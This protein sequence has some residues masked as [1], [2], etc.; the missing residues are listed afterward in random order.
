VKQKRGR[1]GKV[2]PD[3]VRAVRRWFV[4]WN[5]IKRPREIA[6]DLGISTRQ[7]MHIAYNESYRDIQS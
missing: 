4:S 1:R 5:A 7:V 3:D 2:A 6:A